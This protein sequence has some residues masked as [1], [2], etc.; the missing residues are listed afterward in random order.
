MLIKLM[1][2]KDNKVTLVDIDNKEL[3]TSLRPL[4]NPHTSQEIG[5]MTKELSVSYVVANIKE[6]HFDSNT[7]FIDEIKY[8]LDLL[9][10]SKKVFKSYV[11]V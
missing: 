9:K 6:R 10:Q 1:L 3:I 11:S 4:F 7:L 5:L 2:T 8:Q